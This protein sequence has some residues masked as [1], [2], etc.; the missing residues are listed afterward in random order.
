MKRTGRRRRYESP[1]RRQRAAQ[2]R[3]R[4]VSAGAELLHGVPLWNWRALTI[5]RVAER[6]K[7]TERTVYRYFPSESDLRDAVLARLIQEAGVDLDGLRLEG[8]RDFTARVFEYVS[9]FPLERRT[10]RD[11]ALDAAHARQRQAL[12]AAVAPFARQW[13]KADRVIAAAM[14]DVLWSLASYERLAADWKLDPEE[15]IRGVTW[16]MALVEDAIR[17]GRRPGS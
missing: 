10:L 11:S 6:A 12:L 17:R 3:E 1:L 7:V 15:A 13:P 2:T 14:L 8:L 9:S 5:P 16:V 4:I